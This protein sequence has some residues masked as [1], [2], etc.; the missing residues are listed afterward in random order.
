MKKLLLI[1]LCLPMIGLGQEVLDTIFYR[2]WSRKTVKIIEVTQSDVVFQYPQET[3]KNTE[4]TSKIARVTFSSGRIQMFNKELGLH[5]DTV[6]H[7]ENRR[8]NWREEQALKRKKSRPWLDDNKKYGFFN[9]SRHKKIGG[10]N[11]V[12]NAS[13]PSEIKVDLGLDIFSKRRFKIQAYSTYSSKRSND[14]FS[15]A[16]FLGSSFLSKY[17]LIGNKINVDFNLGFGYHFMVSKQKSRDFY[18]SI[19][20]ISGF[21]YPPVTE[22]SGK[23][24]R[25]I[26]TSGASV[27]KE[28]KNFRLG[29]RFN[30]DFESFSKTYWP[31]GPTDD[32]ALNNQ[33]YLLSPEMERSHSLFSK[34][35]FS[36]TL[37]IGYLIGK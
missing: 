3:T 14:S 5:P 8:N 29:V 4:S 26:I 12:Y 27:S 30:L 15:D 31:T 23:Y 1:L 6:V 32:E 24:N 11:S 13:F 7:R 16:K 25:A 17:R 28:I 35:S 34:S 21:I 10:L 2:D 22:Y 33:Y 19:D 36:T 20:P 18:D 9:V 37:S